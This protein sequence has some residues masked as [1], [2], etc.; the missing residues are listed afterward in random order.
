MSADVAAAAGPLALIF[1]ANTALLTRAFEGVGDDQLWHR[2]SQQNNPILWIAGHMVATRA[3]VLQL[4]GDPYDTGWGTR[5]A[6]GAGLGD[7][8]TCPP[9]AEVL[10]VHDEIAARLQARLAALSAAD[11]AKEAVAGPKLPGV[12]TVGDQL[13]FFALHDSYHLGQMAYIRKALGL[14]G[15]VG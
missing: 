12:K 14:S 13:G 6:R 9:K 3:Q 10:R 2:P 8:S 15:L 5:F 4:L 7:E 11:L 1:G